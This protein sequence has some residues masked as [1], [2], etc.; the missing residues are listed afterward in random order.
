MALNKFTRSHQSLEGYPCSSQPSD[1]TNQLSAAAM[2]NWFW[3][4]EV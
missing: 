3:K 1:A 2:E 4:A